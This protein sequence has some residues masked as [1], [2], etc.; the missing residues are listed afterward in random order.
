MKRVSELDGSRL[1]SLTLPEL[2]NL[3]RMRTE[4]VCRQIEGGQNVLYWDFQT[5]PVLEVLNA[6][7][8]SFDS[9]KTKPALPAN[10]YKDP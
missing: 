7:A 9:K 5:G 6:I 3:L 10:A 1:K 4:A 8:V 2:A